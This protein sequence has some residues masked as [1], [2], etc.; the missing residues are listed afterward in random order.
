MMDTATASIIVGLITAAATITA[1][2]IAHSK[3]EE[4]A[5]PPED[6]RRPSKKGIFTKIAR[7]LVYVAMAVIGCGAV[8]FTAAMYSGAY[9]GAQAANVGGIF[10]GV[11]WLVI[12]A[13]LAWRD[14]SN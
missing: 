9:G 1:A 8:T 11:L 14:L 2:L 12:C 7:G 10:A 3:K 5:R 4:P 13:F 6:E